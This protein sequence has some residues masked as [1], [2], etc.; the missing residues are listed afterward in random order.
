[1][2]VNKNHLCDSST[3]K[4]PEKNPALGAFR[5]NG[6][7]GPEILFIDNFRIVEKRL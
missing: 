5:P 7:T 2:I 1:M 6:P 4:I 3:R